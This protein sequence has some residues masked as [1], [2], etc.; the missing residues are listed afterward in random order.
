MQFFKNCFIVF[1][2]SFIALASNVVVNAQSGIENAEI[3]IDTSELEDFENNVKTLTGKLSKLE[4][5]IDFYFNLM[6]TDVTTGAFSEHGY[7]ASIKKPMADVFKFFDAK[8]SPSAI[9]KIKRAQDR[10]LRRNDTK[11]AKRAQAALDD[12]EKLLN[13]VEKCSMFR[14]EDKKDVILTYDIYKSRADEIVKYVAEM[15]KL[16]K[17]LEIDEE[18]LDFF[19]TGY[20]ATIYPKILKG[21][22]PRAIGKKKKIIRNSLMMI[23][24]KDTFNAEKGLKNG[25]D[26]YPDNMEIALLYSYILLINKSDINSVEKGYRYLNEAFERLQTEKLAYNLVRVGLRIERIKEGQILKIIDHVQYRN[27]METLGKLNDMLLYMY[28]KKHSYDE[29]QN[30][31]VDGYAM[32]SDYFKELEEEDFEIAHISPILKF[33]IYLNQSNYEAIAND[34][35]VNDNDKLVKDTYESYKNS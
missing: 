15:G 29:N 24:N 14:S 4:G 11:W 19:L 35:A 23:H 3:K 32:A 10:A 17:H 34:A 7:L 22:K 21:K 18:R 1:I 9:S 2:I 25:T 6:M 12:A 13:E 5:V 27:D 16:I 33:I 20:S 30:L 8:L 28:I 31:L 26:K